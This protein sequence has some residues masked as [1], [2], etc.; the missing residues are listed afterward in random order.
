MFLGRNRWAIADV[1]GPENGANVP[2]CHSPS[3]S[4]PIPR[5]SVPVGMMGL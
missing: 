4:S 2:V 3:P 5:L 1:H